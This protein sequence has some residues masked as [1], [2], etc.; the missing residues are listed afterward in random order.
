MP[1]DLRAVPRRRRAVPRRAR[2][3][4]YD[5]FSG[6]KEVC[7]Y[8]RRLRATTPPCSRR[9]SVVELDRLY[10][11]RR[12]TTTATPRLPARL[13]RRRVHGRRDPASRRRGRQHRGPDHDHGRRRTTSACGRHRSR[14]PTSQT[15]RVVSVS[16]RR[17]SRRPTSTS[18]RCST[19]RGAAATSSPAS[20]GRAHYMD[21]Y[22]EI[23]GID[24]LA[25]RAKTDA[26][27]HD[28][29]GLYERSWTG[30][31]ASAS[32]SR[33]A[34][35]SYADLAHLWR[36]PAYDDVFAADGLV[37]AFGRRSP[38]WASTST[39]RP[40]SISTPRRASSS[41]RAP[42]A[43]PFASPTRSTSSS[44]PQGGQDDYGALL[45]E[46][47]HTEHFAHAGAGPVLRV[48]APGRQRRDRGA[49][50]SSSTTCCSIAPGS[51]A[52][53]A[54]PTATTSS[55]SPPSPT[56]STCAAT[57]PSS[58]TRPSCTSQNGSLAA[59]RGGV[60]PAPQRGAHGRRARRA[61][62][63]PTSTRASTWPATCEPG[64]SRAPC[65]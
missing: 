4:V 33:S 34:S 58:P 27:L 2:E 46:G 51:S 48:S 24:Y 55:A 62:T 54:S 65:A 37:G 5:H 16:R 44:C 9:D 42:S 40:T 30:S 12:A 32:G 21:L 18:T 31:H 64:C 39:H 29:A 26:F 47:G 15:G 20:S 49:S 38:A 61:T 23:K 19:E 52:M 59:M 8:R 1:L 56:S 17:A 25:L 57:P 22:A 6:Q 53:S 13:R 11:K 35:S 41:R 3:G 14:R 36:A 7:D 10:A 60:P 28:T 45:H 43:L 50:P 63:S